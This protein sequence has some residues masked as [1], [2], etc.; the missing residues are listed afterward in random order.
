M[1]IRYSN[2]HRWIMEAYLKELS[3]TTSFQNAHNVLC[4]ERKGGHKNTSPV[5][6]PSAFPRR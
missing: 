1:H 2:T 4:F 5:I 3:L 6:G